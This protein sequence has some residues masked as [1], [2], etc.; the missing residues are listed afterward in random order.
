MSTPDRAPARRAGQR[1]GLSR[2][3]IIEAARRIAEREGLHRLSMRRLSAEVGVMP[4]ALYSHFTDKEALLDALLDS[5][6]GEIEMPDP[7]SVDWRPGLASLMDSS[8]RLLLEH[9]RLVTMFLSRAALGPNASRLGE[10]TFR[11]LRQ[12]GLEGE[13]A[14]EA[15][16]A[17]LIYTL[18][19]AA[20][21]APRREADAPRAKRAQEVFGTLPGDEFP[22]MRRV[23]EHLARRPS[24]GN[25]HAGLR[26]LLDGMSSSINGR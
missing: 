23:A 17:L 9:P 19:F 13:R 25:F 21:Q 2:D 11:F 14:V 4:N 7:A 5:L 20:I 10:V 1:A 3:L 22:E 12:G 24:D 6:L 8:R 16:R 26:W 18:G 15:F